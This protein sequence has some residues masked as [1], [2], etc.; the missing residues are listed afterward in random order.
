MFFL[1]ACANVAKMA[2][3]NLAIFSLT[4]GT[5]YICCFVFQGSNKHATLTP[6][7]DI[8]TSKGKFETLEAWL[9]SESQIV[10]SKNASFAMVSDIESL[11]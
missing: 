1:I 11:K 2:S 9:C 6:T 5:S 4:C 3:L 7:G 10:F 8:V